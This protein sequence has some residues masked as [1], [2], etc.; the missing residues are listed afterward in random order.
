MKVQELWRLAVPVVLVFA[1]ACGSDDSGSPPPAGETGDLSIQVTGLP[2]GSTA[3]ATV[4]GPGGYNET[5][6]SGTLLSGL[7]VGSYS[8]I[9]APVADAGFSY[10]A[11]AAAP[12]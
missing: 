1:A 12:R 6:V 10:Q 5:T 2:P 8:V 4:T 3:A 7:D 9:G 11:S